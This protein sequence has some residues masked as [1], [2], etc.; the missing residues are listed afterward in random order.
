MGVAAAQR[1]LT[2]AGLKPGDYDVQMHYY[3]NN[4]N[5][6]IAVEGCEDVAVSQIDALP[7]ST[8]S[9]CTSLLETGN[10]DGDVNGNLAGRYPVL[11]MLDIV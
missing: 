3:G 8:W 7:T 1:A 2:D 9:F 11:E 6:L 10:C 5:Q 4:G